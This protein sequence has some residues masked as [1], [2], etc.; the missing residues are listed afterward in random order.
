MN[1]YVLVN[2][3]CSLCVISNAF[4]CSSTVS[5]N[6]CLSGY[7]LSN[8][9]CQSCLLNCA[10]CVSAYD[11]SSCNSGYYLN[12]SIITCNTCPVG[13]SIC[14]QYNPSQCTVCNN[15]YQLSNSICSMV[16]CNI[17][18]CLFCTSVS[19]CKQCNLFYYWNGNECV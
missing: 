17:P 11:C 16:T 15:G 7:Y 5:A 8:S 10:S 12:T 14:N 1:P 19:V 13:C 3:S 4:S 9:Y 6:V 18:F 2:S